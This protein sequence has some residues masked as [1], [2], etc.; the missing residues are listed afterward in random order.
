MVVAK[1]LTK[2]VSSLMQSPGARL[3]RYKQDGKW[4]DVDSGDVNDYIE[5]VAQF[6]YTAKGLQNVGRNPSRCD[7][8][9]PNWGRGER[10][11]AEEERRHRGATRRV[12]ARQYPYYM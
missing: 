9:W 11:R 3:F 6:P 7:G 5:S 10:E 4:Q 12:G 8:C 2:F 1:D